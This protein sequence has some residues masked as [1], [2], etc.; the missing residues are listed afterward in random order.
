MKY[1][2]ISLTVMYCIAFF[3]IILLQIRCLKNNHAT[4]WWILYAFEIIL[5]IISFILYAYFRN[6]NDVINSNTSIIFALIF[7]SSAFITMTFDI[8]NDIRNKDN[9]K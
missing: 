9:Y 5:C 8:Q 3:L 4:L 6:F 2:H 7:G 1:F